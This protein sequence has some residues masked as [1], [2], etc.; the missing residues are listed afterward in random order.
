MDPKAIEPMQLAM[1]IS[2]LLGDRFELNLAN[3]ERRL[4]QKTDD[5]RNEILSEVRKLQD[6]QAEQG[7]A[8][9]RMETRLDEGDKRF[10]D[11][12]VRLEKLEERERMSAIGLAKLGGA[13]GIGALLSRWLAI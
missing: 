3:V 7:K 4:A 1:E 11:I 13:A 2:K 6:E 12:E 9:V 10:K 8:L 5:V